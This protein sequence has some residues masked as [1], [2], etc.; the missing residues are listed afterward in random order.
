M[1]RLPSNW[2]N[3]YVS[4]N[5][6]YRSRSWLYQFAP[7]HQWLLSIVSKQKITFILL[8]YTRSAKTKQT[9]LIQLD[10]TSSS[11]RTRKPNLPANQKG[12]DKS[13]T[14]HEKLSARRIQ[15]CGDWF[16][17]SKFHPFFQNHFLN[18]VRTK[19]CNPR[20]IGFASSNLLMPRSH[21]LLR[22]LGLIVSWFFSYVVMEAKPKYVCS[23]I[24]CSRVPA[25]V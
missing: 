15:I 17:W 2:H 5:S 16:V 9:W 8:K 7:L 13:V 1:N 18:N 22:C 25:K 6:Y 3:I 11:R 4:A 12:Y 23:I 20:R 24:S 19:R 10:W 21:I 14:T